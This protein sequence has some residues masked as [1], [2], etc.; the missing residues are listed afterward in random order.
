M[1]VAERMVWDGERACRG[2]AGGE[3]EGCWKARWEGA[4]RGVLGR[5][6]EFGVR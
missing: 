1:T 4:L 6:E 3:R 2:W 5:W